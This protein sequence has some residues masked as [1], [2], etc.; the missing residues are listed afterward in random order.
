MLHAN[1]SGIAHR[2]ETHM[3]VA[4]LVTVV[5]AI[6]LPDNLG[7]SMVTA[8]A[9]WFAVWVLSHTWGWL[10]GKITKRK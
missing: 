2:T 8:C 9:C 7:G 5:R 3:A 10:W 4:G 6:Q 1:A